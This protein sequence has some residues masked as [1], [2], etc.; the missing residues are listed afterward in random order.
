MRKL[1]LFSVGKIHFG[2]KSATY[3]LFCK[4]LI[5]GAYTD[6]LWSVENAI[7]TNPEQFRAFIKNRKG[8][9]RIPT[10]MLYNN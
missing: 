1:L 7:L 5:N 4:R 9:S 2:V 10:S 8:S 3:Y 6:H